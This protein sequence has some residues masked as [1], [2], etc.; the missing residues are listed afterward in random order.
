MTNQKP[1]F[2][3][4]IATN[5]R[6]NLIYFRENNGPYVR[7][8]ISDLPAPLLQLLIA[9]DAGKQVKINLAEVVEE[10]EA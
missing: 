10:K 4:T 2:E 1:T 3:I 9:L 6:K 5:V 7:C 8:L